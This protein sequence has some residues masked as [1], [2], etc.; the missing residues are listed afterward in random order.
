MVDWYDCCD[1]A[2]VLHQ[3]NAPGLSARHTID[4]CQALRL[5][6]GNANDCSSAKTRISSLALFVMVHNKQTTFMFKG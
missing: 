6:G 5:E 2:V 4:Q 1:G 3:D